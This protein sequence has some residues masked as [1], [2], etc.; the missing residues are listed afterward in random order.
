MRRDEIVEA[1]AVAFCKYQGIPYTKRVFHGQMEAVLAALIEACPLV[2]GPI[3][4]PKGIAGAVAILPPDWKKQIYAVE[5]PAR[6]AIMT[7]DV[8]ELVSAWLT[9]A[10]EKTDGQ[11]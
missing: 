2:A 8:I 6:F 10:G 9:G 3:D 4:D 7:D 5:H 11:T 1:M